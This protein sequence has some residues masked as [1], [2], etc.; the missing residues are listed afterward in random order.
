MITDEAK[1]RYRILIFWKKHG[2]KATLDA[3]EVSERTL[4]SWRASLKKGNGMVESLNP[5]S[6][7]PHV[8][9]KR[10]WSFVITSEILRVR[11]EHPN[12]GK[13]KI[14]V[15]LQAFCI[16]KKLKCPKIRTIGRI[17][18]DHPKKM[19][20]FPQKIGHDGKVKKKKGEKKTRKPK[21]FKATHPGH[22]VSLDTVEFILW[23]KRV[24]VITMLDL[25]SR[26]G[27][28]Y[29]TTSHASK[30][31]EEFFTRCLAIFPYP[32]QFVLTDNGS[33]FMK[34]FDERLRELCMTH[35]HAY[36]K[37]PKMNAHCERFN[38][39]VQD[40]FFINHKYLLHNPPYCNEKLTTWLG[41]YNDT[42]PHHSLNLLSPKQFLN[43][44]EETIKTH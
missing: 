22:C 38:R 40:E 28:A 13:E 7:A 24:Y 33:E 37:T 23:G 29:T 10:T 42:R 41:W 36:P 4:K 17:I 16:E 3:F 21:G 14:F 5:K 31:A 34:H 18:A 9:R 1:K 35:W 25:F 27:F 6:R 15:H 11:E 19:R 20:T 8:R 32:I 12:L 2:L 30:A 43:K 26:Y 39:I 44:Y